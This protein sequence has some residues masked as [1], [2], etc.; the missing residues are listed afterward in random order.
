MIAQ[1]PGVPPLPFYGAVSAIV[2]DIQSIASFFT[3]DPVW[4]VFDENG[5][6]VF[7]VDSVQDLRAEARSRISEF[8]VE[9]GEFAS[10]NKVQEPDTVRLRLFKST[11]GETARTAFLVLLDAAKKQTFKFSV[12]TPE[13]TYLNA[14]IEDYSYRRDADSGAN[15]II[16]DVSFKEIR[17]VAIT[18]TDAALSDTKVKN[19]ASADPVP[20]GKVQP[21]TADVSTLA[22]WAGKTKTQHGAQGSW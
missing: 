13:K 14:C 18:Y 19:A 2:L 1:L 11:G 21:Q 4:G 20:T 6:L 12:V 3:S 16:A 15:A 22:K 17:E 7:E 10:Y 5:N 9:E 8:P